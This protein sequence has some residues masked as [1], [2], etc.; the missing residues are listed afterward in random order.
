MNRGSA[1][2]PKEAAL[3]VLEL[4][5]LLQGLGVKVAVLPPQLRPHLPLLR[6]H[7]TGEDAEVIRQA[8][9]TAQGLLEK[10]SSAS[11]MW[12]AN[13]A[14]VTPCVDALD[15]RLHITAANLF[16]NLH[17][18][19]EAEDTYDTLAAIFAQVPGCVVHPPLAAAAGLHDEGA[20]NHMR[21]SP[22][23][24]AR[25][26]HVF[27]WGA[28]G[29][30]RDPES[31]RQSLSAS[32]AVQA[33][34]KIPAEAAL[35]LRQNPEV[36]RDGVFHNDVIAVSNASVLLVH[37]L[38]FDR[39]HT[40]LQMID[41]AYQRLHPGQEL[42]I[43]V[44]SEDELSVEEA[45]HSY[46]FNSQI[47]SLPSGRMALIAPVEAQD[48]YDGK[49]A[50]LMERIRDDEGNPIDEVHYV[51]LRQSMRNGGGPACLRLRVAMT[52]AQVEA[53]ASSTKVM[54]DDALLEALEQVILDT[55]PESLVAEDLGNPALFH[56]SLKAIAAFSAVLGVALPGVVAE[57]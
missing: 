29:T 23:H 16:T 36:I 10:A 35:F 39:G 54:V 24:S 56:A 46:F 37:E 34:H 9:L 49:A 50:A 38:A 27:V 40:A 52:E 3:Q 32:R 14:T 13:A 2:S 41:E 17:R 20:A 18:R 6:Q 25:G 12:T 8:S 57:V 4:M 53:L 48:L 51:D 19:I 33:Q 30:E 55:Y 1:S 22:S 7:F 42:M 5:R 45:V 15:G 28:N 21:L 31:A 43:L 44:V 11:A 47:I 26:L